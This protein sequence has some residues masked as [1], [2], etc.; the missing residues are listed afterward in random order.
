VLMAEVHPR[1]GTLRALDER[2]NGSPMAYSEVRLTS[3]RSG[4]TRCPR[5]CIGRSAWRCPWAARGRGL[6]LVSLP[7]TQEG[8]ARDSGSAT[9]S[10]EMG[11]AG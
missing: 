5:D 4:N 1:V 8:P 9:T 6:L 11:V 7:S 2:H 10:S 3:R